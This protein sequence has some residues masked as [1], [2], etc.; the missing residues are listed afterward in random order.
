MKLHKYEIVNAID[1]VK[2]IAPKE[3]TIKALEG[4]LVNNGYL[5]AS[6]M[7]VTVTFKLEG[8]EGAPVHHSSKGIRP[9]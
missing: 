1:K 4:V 6:N 5:I 3:A 2:S 8:S 7:E 9:Y